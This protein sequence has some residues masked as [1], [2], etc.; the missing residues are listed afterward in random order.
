MNKLEQIDKEIFEMEFEPESKKVMDYYNLVRTN[1]LPIILIFVVS[2]IV[3]TIYIKNY[4]TV[5]RSVSTI[6]IDKPQS[7]LDKSDN[8]FMQIAM[9]ERVLS[10]QIEMMRSYYIKEIIFI[11]RGKYLK[12]R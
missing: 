12:M 4:R 9:S 5:W 8:I 7:I 3:T 10:N 2:L 1:L 6:K 11:L